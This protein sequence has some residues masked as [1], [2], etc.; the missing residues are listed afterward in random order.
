M[1]FADLAFNILDRVPD[2]QPRDDREGK[3]SMD[4]KGL[5][6]LYCPWRSNRSQD[7]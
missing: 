4:P 6:G 3:K 1:Y 5:L 2:S 7:F